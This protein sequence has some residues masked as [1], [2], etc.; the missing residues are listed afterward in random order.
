MARSD[1]SAREWAVGIAGG[2]E[3]DAEAGAGTVMGKAKVGGGGGGVSVDDERTQDNATIA[4]PRRPD[5]RVDRFAMDLTTERAI[6]EGCRERT[7][8]SPVG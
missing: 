5:R 3:A 6:I 2:A 8:T 7:R 1:E 4:A